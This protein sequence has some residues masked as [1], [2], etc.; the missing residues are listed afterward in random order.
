MLK[1]CDFILLQLL[2]SL[3]DLHFCLSDNFRQSIFFSS[4]CFFSPETGGSREYSRQEKSPERWLKGRLS[5][6]TDSNDIQNILQLLNEEID[7]VI[8]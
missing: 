6:L 1:I 4:V 8:R 7:K 2:M 3:L 5:Y